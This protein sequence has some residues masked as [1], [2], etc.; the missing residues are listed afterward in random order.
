MSEFVS[1]GTVG[2]SDVRRHHIRLVLGLIRDGDGISRADLVARTGLTKPTVTSLVSDLDKRGI[3]RETGT[4]ETASRG[5]PARLLELNAA[6]AVTL[7]IEVNIDRVVVSTFD[8]RGDLVAENVEQFDESP[9]PDEVVRIAANAAAELEAAHRTLAGVAVAVPAM[10]DAGV[11]RS[12][13]HLGWDEV[14]LA[15]ML[16]ATTSIGS[17]PVIVDRLVNFSAASERG[18]RGGLADD[19]VVVYGDVGLGSAHLVDGEIVRGAQGLAGEAGHT[20][21]DPDGPMHECGRRGCA[22]ALIGLGPLVRDLGLGEGRVGAAG[23]TAPDLLSRISDLAVDADPETREVLD[24]QGRWLGRLVST[25]LH[26]MNPSELLLGGHFTTLAPLYWDA[27]DDELRVRALP[28]HLRSCEINVS[29]LGA[30]SV[31]RGA[32]RVVADGYLARF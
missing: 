26:L 24:R 25:L 14:R 13:P 32:H 12:G 5:R 27:F 20:L 1:A 2:S 3:V 28:Q 8:L 16:H 15:D 4:R 10:I 21:L 7:V 11:V 29:E 17:T 22:A 18:S 23:M 9:H 6:H 30:E 31:R 19:V